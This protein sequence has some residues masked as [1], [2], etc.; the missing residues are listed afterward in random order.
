S[1]M[2]LARL[3][4]A[5][6][7]F[8]DAEEHDQYAAA[9]SHLPLLL[10]TALFGLLRSSPSWSDMAPMASSGFRDMTRLASGD[11][12]MSVGICV[13]N[14]EAVAH[15]LERLAGELRRLQ[16]LLQD[17]QDETLLETFGKAQMERE[18]FLV[19]PARRVE[20][21]SQAAGARRELLDILVGGW[22]AERMRKAQELP[23]LM[24]EAQT[25]EGKKRSTL[26]E[27]IAEDI[28]RD[29]EKR[30]GGPAAGAEQSDEK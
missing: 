26:A 7:L 25:A 13:T 10:A 15:W 1:E 12:K 8:L 2:G 4:G 6:P 11:P 27:R 24:K 20:E 30:S 14:R 21:A 29:L 19:Q 9:V 22:A 18:T 5:E 28:R 23:Q 16:D 17:A 3:V